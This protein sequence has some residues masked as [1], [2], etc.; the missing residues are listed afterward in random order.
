MKSGRPQLTIWR[1]R[2]ACRIPKF[3]NTDSQYV[4]LI[5]FPLQQW[6]LESASMLCNISIASTVVISETECV[7]CAVPA[8]IE[9]IFS[10]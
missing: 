7:Y 1:M 10:P 9:G 6:L 5:A 3:I 8:E 2:I 4:I